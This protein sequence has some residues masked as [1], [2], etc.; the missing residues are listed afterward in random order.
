LYRGFNLNFADTD[1]SKWY[2]EG[3]SLHD[4]NNEIVREKIENFR[5]VNGHLVA[6]EIVAEWFPQIEADVFLSHSHKDA[7]QIIGFAGWLSENFGLTSFID[8]CVW[9]HSDKLLKMIDNEYCY[10]KQTKTYFYDNRN[11]STSHVY[12]MLSNALTKMIYDCECVIFANTPYSIS[13]DEY[14]LSKGSTISPWIYSE[15]AMTKLVQKRSPQEH[16]RIIAKSAS[17]EEH[18]ENLVVQYDVDLSHL[19]PMNSLDLDLWERKNYK[20]G[21]DS[22]D[23]LYQ[24]KKT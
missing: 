1:F 18:K 5:D 8:S 3:K 6:S 4:A 20:K 16:R 10:N 17:L 21:S 23:V 7:N 9:G 24:I 2:R 13:V 22:L 12:M 15:I 19:V 14:V 11:R